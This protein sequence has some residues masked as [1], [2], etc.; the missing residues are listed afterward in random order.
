MFKLDPNQQ[1][2]ANEWIKEQNEK[3]YAQQK[4]EKGRVGD[5]AWTFGKAYYGAIGGAITYSFTPTGLGVVIKIQHG[6]TDEELDLTDH[7]W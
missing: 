5:N 1:K 6:V 2:Q 7:D 3:V 4:E